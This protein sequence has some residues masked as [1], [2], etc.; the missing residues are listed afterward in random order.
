MTFPDFFKTATGNPPYDYQDRLAMAPRASR[1]ISI[2]TGLGK[3]AAVILAWLWNRVAQPD[4]VARNTWPRRLI[5]CLPMRT[6]VEQTRDEA[7]KWIKE[8][9]S[10]N[11]LHGK[12]PKVIILMGGEE[13]T[14]ED[15]D[16]DLY[17]EDNTIIIGTQD[18]LLSRALNRGYGMSR[19]R[20][21][22]HF[23][24]LNNDCLWVMDETQ[25]IGVGVE[26]SAQLDGFRNHALPRPE[27]LPGA[28]PTWWMSATLDDARLTT[29]DHPLPDGGWP[30]LS[31]GPVDHALPM[32]KRRLDS[33][34][35]LH[36]ASIYLSKD[37]KPEHYA[38]DV[39]RMVLEKHLPGHLTLIIV[40]RV[41]R[42]QAIYEALRKAGRTKDIAL[43]HSRF[44]APDRRSHQELLVEGTGDR[45]VV[46]TQAI[47]AGVDVSARILFTELA[48]WSSL[49]QRFG[50]CNRG[51]EFNAEGSNVY[52]MDLTFSEDKDTAPYA[53]AELTDA[54]A[55]LNKL[56][57]VGPSTLSN[58]NVDPPA[59][60][61]PV[62]RRKD[63]IDLF[64]TTPDL[65]GHDLD[66]SRYIRDGEDND[67]QV[68]WRDLGPAPFEP[69]GKTPEPDRD[70][71]CGVALYRFQTFL[72]KL[73]E[74]KD[75][76]KIWQW[77]GLNEKWSPSTRARPGGVYLIDH[78]VGGYDP[79]I[80]WTGEFATLKKETEWVLPV[81]EAEKGD[82]PDS[83]QSDP[84]TMIGKAL[85]L[86]DH[87][88]HVVAML[89]SI[90]G[91]LAINLPP[92]W[93]VP[94]ISAAQWHDVGKAMD[95]FQ[96]LLRSAADENAP[97]GIL[98]KSGGSGGTM[99]PSRKQFRHELASALAWLANNEN[100]EQGDLIAYIIAAHH[101]KVRLSIRSLPDEKPPADRITSMI[102]RGIMDG[103]KLPAIRMDGVTMPETTL[104]LDLMRMGHDEEGRPSWLSR[105]I[106]LRDSIGPFG[107]VWLEMLLR[108]ADMRASATESGYPLI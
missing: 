105:M 31:L 32:V 48:P 41:P 7:E 22:I 49:V 25:L 26:T 17:P 76:R 67:V 5:Y 107:L 1:L 100:A 33:V 84:L 68:F 56:A 85:T 23:G 81:P 20:W 82:A 37:L 103:D 89:R 55:E 54:R 94:L 59:V 69:A 75:G 80:G 64:D 30:R 46:A 101:G 88:S 9:S 70:E 83:T 63:L 18:M 45:I 106:T 96:I 73:N 6:L 102:A 60:V 34:K 95:D 74:A 93:S 99:P 79:L 61:R 21:P 10:K 52:W 8:L 11:L 50:R 19:Y 90:I 14:P 38:R 16:W 57:A 40:N 77:D 108:A 58:I 12:P 98:A 35:H 24:L 78:R 2:P 3:T 43:I 39:A 15:K 42:A 97:D 47:E 72:K 44:R 28:C 27:G 13:T 71:L 62:I 65:A 51:G 86:E 4:T 66:I 53:A 87:T 91:E 104:R 36:Q 29:V 92:Q